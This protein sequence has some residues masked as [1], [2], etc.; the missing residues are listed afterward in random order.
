SREW[1]WLSRT[2]GAVGG[3]AKRRRC[4]ERF[5]SLPGVVSQPRP[6]CRASARRSQEA[7]REVSAGRQIRVNFQISLVGRRGLSLLSR[8]KLR[9]HA[10][11]LQRVLH[12]S[13]RR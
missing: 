5:Q 9:Q 8:R 3:H 4:R 12:I 1:L 13:E 7:K 11:N 10:E 6:E 2:W